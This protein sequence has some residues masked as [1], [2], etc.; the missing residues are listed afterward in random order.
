MNIFNCTWLI[1]QEINKNELITITGNRNNKLLLIK[2]I[3]NF[4]IEFHN[5]SR[6][7]K[8][9]HGLIEIIIFCILNKNTN[10]KYNDSRQNNQITFCVKFFVLIRLCYT[11]MVK[12]S[13]KQQ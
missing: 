1:Q 13:Y 3:C 9:K 10:Y 6:K 7:I 5:K 11:K 4:L 12:I 8:K 2:V